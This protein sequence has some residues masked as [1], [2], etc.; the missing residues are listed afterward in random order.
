MLQ[1]LNTGYRVFPKYFHLIACIYI[2][3][4]IKNIFV[5]NFASRHL[6]APH[7]VCSWA[8]VCGVCV[9]AAPSSQHS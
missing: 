8:A 1:I 2:E 4:S 3:S 6:K 9:C 7:Q 5:D